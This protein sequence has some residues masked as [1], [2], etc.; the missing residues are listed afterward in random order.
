M[1]PRYRES[2]RA[3]NSGLGSSPPRQLRDRSRDPCIRTG[4]DADVRGALLPANRKCRRRSR[5][6]SAVRRPSGGG[7]TIAMSP[8]RSRTSDATRDE[9][10]RA[11]TASDVRGWGLRT[12]RDSSGS[13][14]VSCVCARVGT[15]LPD[16]CFVPTHSPVSVGEAG[17]E[18][19]LRQTDQ[20]TVDETR[21][22]NRDRTAVA[23]QRSQ[24]RSLGTC[25]AGRCCR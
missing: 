1:H 5:H 16:A 12:L 13:R 10:D 22:A 15:R 17:A 7:E 23:G 9:R 24:R 6:S 3:K 2:R 20:S 19:R 8:K 25:S 18:R 11:D 4:M 21:P 14:F